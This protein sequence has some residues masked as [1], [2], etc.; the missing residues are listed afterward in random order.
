M[1]ENLKTIDGGIVVEADAQPDLMLARIVG[2]MTDAL[3]DHPLALPACLGIY[4]EGMLPGVEPTD[5]EVTGE[6][7]AALWDVP[8]SRA[9]WLSQARAAIQE[10][11]QEC[12]VETEHAD[13]TKTIESMEASA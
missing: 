1:S 13:G 6:M 8:E 12:T 4:T 2:E 3:D 11:A 10:W 5:V 7:L 9:V